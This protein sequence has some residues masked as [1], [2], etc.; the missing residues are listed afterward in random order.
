MQNEANDIKQLFETQQIRILQ[1]YD[2][3]LNLLNTLMFAPKYK[4]YIENYEKTIKSIMRKFNDQIANKN[5]FKQ[6]LSFDLLQIRDMCDNFLN[7]YNEIKA[8]N[9]SYGSGNVASKIK[10]F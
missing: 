3:L 10:P 2:K 6:L 9:K 7:I 5:D 8:R 1:E 4:C